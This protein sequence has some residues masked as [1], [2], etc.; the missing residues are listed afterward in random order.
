MRPGRDGLDLDER[1]EQGHVTG[2]FS[3]RF[4]HRRPAWEN[5]DHYEK[6][7]A[8]CFYLT[9]SWR[10]SKE[11][12]ARDVVLQMNG[13]TN[14]SDDSERE[15]NEIAAY[16]LR[17]AM[18]ENNRKAFASLL[19]YPFYQESGL[20][21]VSVWNSPEEVANNYGKIMHFSYH[22]IYSSVPH[23]LQTSSLGSQFMNGSIFI[24]HGRVT[25]MC[26]GAC[27]VK[28]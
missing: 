27:S 13:E 19:R 6:Y 23:F 8:K 7:P 28:P 15:L 14:P 18:L 11:T 1:D 22:E 10:S 9:G 17:R 2:H 12:E 24:V 4:F 26:D 25:R 3:L 16:K 21:V 20:Q 5:L